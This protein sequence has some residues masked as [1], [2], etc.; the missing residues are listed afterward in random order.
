MTLLAPPSPMTAEGLFELQDDGGRIE[1]VAG[2]LAR[3]TPTGGAHGALAVAL[4][5]CSTSTSKQ[6]TSASAAAPRQGSSWRGIPIQCAPRTPPSCWHRAFPPRASPPATGPSP[7]ISPSKWSRHRTASPTSTSRSPSTSPPEP[8]WSGWWNPKPAWSTSTGRNSRLKCWE[9]RTTSRAARCCRGS[10]VRY[11]GSFPR[12]VHRDKPRIRPHREFR[13]VVLR[14]YGTSITST[15]ILPGISSSFYQA[16]PNLLTGMGILGTF[17][18]LAG[19]VGSASSYR[20]SVS[21]G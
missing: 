19:G 5:A 6:T 1:L 18:G 3:M 7:P 11:G 17:L 4:G 10:A 21:D 9:R 2:E 14:D 20:H 13:A 8:A 12:I 15:I 16:V